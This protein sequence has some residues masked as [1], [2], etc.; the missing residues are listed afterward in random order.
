MYPQLSAVADRALVEAVFCQ[1]VVFAQRA[2][3]VTPIPTPMPPDFVSTSP[4]LCHG[5]A[6]DFHI[7]G[8]RYGQRDCLVIEE[9][10]IVSPRH[11]ALR[12]LDFFDLDR[13]GID[14]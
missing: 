3:R 5:S 14:R 12:R 7:L 8:F 1:P 6:G 13:Q 4:R 2:D 11:E 9:A 10:V